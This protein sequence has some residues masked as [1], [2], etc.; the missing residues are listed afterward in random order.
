M[1]FPRLPSLPIPS[2]PRLFDLIPFLRLLRCLAIALILYLISLPPIW[3]TRLVIVFLVFI[4]K[5]NLMMPMYRGAELFLDD[6]LGILIYL[7]SLPHAIAS[8][9]LYAT[10]MTVASICRTIVIETCCLQSWVAN[11]LSHVLIANF[12]LVM[13][14]LYTNSVR[15]RHFWWKAGSYFRSLAKILGF[16]AEEALARPL[17]QS[18][19]DFIFGIMIPNCEL[20]W[21][22]AVN[23]CANAALCAI[24]VMFQVVRAV[25]DAIY[26]AIHVF[27]SYFIS[28]AS[29][30]ADFA[31]ALINPLPPT[32]LEEISSAILVAQMTLFAVIYMLGMFARSFKS[33]VFR[34]MSKLV[35]IFSSINMW[36]KQTYQ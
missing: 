36:L 22:M 14:T 35:V 11:A 17:H 6:L 30:H 25:L 1:E 34:R 4:A 8:F 29:S 23:R 24:T 2:N 18:T 9:A 27:F 15:S 20:G 31:L 13:A 33:A 21:E 28:T 32:V 12:T 5:I 10:D 7:I 16:E 19:I 3:L 26:F